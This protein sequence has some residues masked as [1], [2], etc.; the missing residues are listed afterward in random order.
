MSWLLNI[1]IGVTWAGCGSYL[2]HEFPSE[3]SCY[4]ALA[5]MKTGD[6]PIM[7]S[8]NKRNTVALC[9]PKPTRPKK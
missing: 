9:A 2:S 1:C 5:A 8:K 6:Q 7:E 4:R 3:E